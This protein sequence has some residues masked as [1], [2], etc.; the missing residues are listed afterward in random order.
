MKLNN[1]LSLSL[2]AAGLSVSAAGFAASS[3][4]QDRHADS[5]AVFKKLDTNGDDKLTA[6]E[7][8]KLPNVMQQRMLAKVDTNQDGKID[9][10]EFE[11]RAKQRADRMFAK[12]DKNGDGSLS[13]DEMK[14]PMGHHRMGPPPGDPNDEQP[15]KPD[16]TSDKPAHHD[17]H[18]DGHRHGKHRHHH[19]KP[20]TDEIF[21]H[22]DTDNDGYVSAAEWDKAAEQ[23]HHRHGH[24]KPAPDQN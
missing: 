6:A 22:M 19:G 9:K 20:S 5:Q 18:H 14:P 4:D 3:N 10:S 7:M 15:P 23:W 17:R 12:L 21:A 24:P 16:E 1:Y 13:A 2:I 11:A 8:T